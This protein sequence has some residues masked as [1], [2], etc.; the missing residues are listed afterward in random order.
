MDNFQVKLV[1]FEEK[2]VQ[3]V[4]AQLLK[5][6]EE[7]TGDTQIEEPVTETVVLEATQGETSPTFG[8]NDVLSY[9]KTKFNR[10]V[11]SLDELF[12]EKLGVDEDL[13]NILSQEGFRTLEDIAY[14]PEN[15]MLEIE[16]FDKD[17][18][19]EL[20]SRANN[21]LL[22]QALTSKIE[23]VIEPAQ[24][25]LEMEGMT[26]HLAYILASSG[27]ITKEDL[28]EQAV[29]DLCEIKEIDKKMA[30]KLIMTARKHWFEQL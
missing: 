16:N 6:H 4:E 7:K 11:N 5:Q 10:E 13:A 30:A 20:K 19:A 14:V 15:E 12:I 3:E 1:D 28:A 27:I 26:R 24:D 18:V 9:L 2:S 25:L 17:L 8:D 22:Q 23:K 21:A 29:D